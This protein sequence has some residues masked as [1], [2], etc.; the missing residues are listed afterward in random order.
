M[1]IA[2]DVSGLDFVRD[3]H[4]KIHRLGYKAHPGIRMG[5]MYFSPAARATAT[6]ES[7]DLRDKGCVSAIQDQGSC[8][9]CWAFSITKA[10]ESA[11]K[12]FQGGKIVDLAEQA[13]VSCDSGAWG[14][15][16]GNMDDM[17]FVI[18]N[19]LPLEKDFP[20]TA[21]NGRCKDAPVAVKGIRWGYVGQPGK[22]PTLA[23][24]QA[25]VQSYGV[26]STTVAAGG[27]DWSN[28]GD[29]K[30]CRNGGTNHMVDIV[31]WKPL[32][33]TVKLIGVNSWG[34]DWGESGFFY[35]EQGCD[36]IASGSESVSFVV[37]EEAPVPT[38]PPH[39]TLPANITAY[40]GTELVLGVRSENGVTYSWA[41]G[42]KAVGLEGVPDTTSLIYVSPKVD[43]VYQITA[44]NAAGTVYSLVH[45][46][47]IARPDK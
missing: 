10:L 44:K 45:V 32:D 26:L 43:T 1:A 6:P 18:K 28:G 2:A 25:A 13:L 24:I 46:H 33:G 47:L 5:V 8:G 14:C 11:V 27:N 29:M 36:N 40:E 19:G 22:E 17:D 41:D 39:A 31:G 16:G 38:T 9:S 42:T 3:N 4:G 12:C 7:Y 15:G 35:A 37:V 21:S 34:S 20:Y 23:E 30:G